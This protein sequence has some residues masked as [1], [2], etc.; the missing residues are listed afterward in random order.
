MALPVTGPFNTVVNRPEFYRF[1]N[2]YRQA[3]PVD[4]PLAY[5]SRELM[6]VAQTEVSPASANIDVN[7]L[8]HKTVNQARIVAYDDLKSKLGSS[9][10]LAV[11]LSETNKSLQAIY[12]VSDKLYKISR[13][14]KR[15]LTEP[16]FSDHAVKRLKARDLSGTFLEVSYGLLPTYQDIHAS[17]EVLNSKPPPLIIKGYGTSSLR[18]RLAQGP[19][20]YTRYL[21]ERDTSCR[22]HYGTQVNVSNPNLFLANQL[23]LVNPVSFL[24]ERAPWS[25]VL[26]WFINLDQFMGQGS[27]FY[28]LS[29]S[30]KYTSTKVTQRK[31]YQWSTTGLY[32]EY[33][34]N[35]FSRVTNLTTPSLGFRQVKA[36][37][38]YRAANAVS[39]LANNLRSF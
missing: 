24:V 25:F 22:V 19:N 2:S 21:R 27:D 23:G 6:R 3:K 20:A 8:S 28:G 18:E 12:S 5:D 36:W 15:G 31:R 35:S 17:V 32:G 33:L 11:A 4:R 10:E 39:L 37:G 13:S 7:L 26:N 38:W 30:Y 14:I 34:Q 16:I 29:L 9:A 1:K